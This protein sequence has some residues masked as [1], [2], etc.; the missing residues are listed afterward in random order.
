M[1]T[2]IRFLAVYKYLCIPQNTI[3]TEYLIFSSEHF[4]RIPVLPSNKIQYQMEQKHH[5]LIS[6]TLKKLILNPSNT[7]F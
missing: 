7:T 6:Q 2:Y 1:N 5:C 4:L 3:S